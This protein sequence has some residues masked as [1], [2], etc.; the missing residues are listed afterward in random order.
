MRYVHDNLITAC[1]PRGRGAAAH[2][3]VEALTA[4]LLQLTKTAQAETVVATVT[5]TLQ[6]LF[7]AT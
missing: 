6:Q 2:L 1:R 7:L 4:Q 5:N 3:S